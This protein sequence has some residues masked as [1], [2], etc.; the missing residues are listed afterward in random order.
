MHFP[1]Y[2]SWHRLLTRFP[3]NFRL[4]V[5]KTYKTSSD[6]HMKTW[7]SL[8]RRAFLKNP[9]T[10][11]FYR[12]A[13]ALSI[14]FKMKRLK[15]ALSCIKTKSNSKFTVKLAVRSNYLFSVYLIAQLFQTY[16]F[17]I[18]CDNGMFEVNWLCK[19]LCGSP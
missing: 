12:R 5:L 9:S 11:S 19:H 13:Y 2:L 14:G 1:F 3:E 16:V 4:K 17:L 15:K 18:I 6:C 10:V 7:R 8:T